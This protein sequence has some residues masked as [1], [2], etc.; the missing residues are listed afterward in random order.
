MIVD[1]AADWVGLTSGCDLVHANHQPMPLVPLEQRTEERVLRQVGQG[2]TVVGS[3]ASPL[4]SRHPERRQCAHEA[5]AVALP[6]GLIQAGRP[7][8]VKR[9]LVLERPREGPPEQVTDPPLQLAVNP[10][11]DDCGRFGL[12]KVH[13][14]PMVRQVLRQRGMVVDPP[15]VLVKDHGASG[16]IVARVRATQPSLCP[17][18]V[19]G[20]NAFVPVRGLEADLIL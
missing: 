11:Q 4:G 13:Q 8:A 1:G 20:Q 10:V 2:T 15:P 19:L 5:V 7:S 18:R 12:K 3:G 14:Y 17:L 9:Q 16:Q 6:E